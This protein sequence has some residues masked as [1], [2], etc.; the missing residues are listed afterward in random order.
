MFGARPIRGALRDVVTSAVGSRHQPKSQFDLTSLRIFKPTIGLP[1]WLRR[2]RA[3]GLAPIYNYFNRVPQPADEGYS[4]R[5][6]YCRDYRGGQWTYDGN[7][8][9]DFAL[10]VGTPVTASAPGEVLRVANDMKRGGLKVCIDHGRGLFT[11]SNH[12]AR[13]RVQPGD[14]VARGDII[15]RSGA[16]GIEFMLFFPW[17][18]PHL[19][20]NVWL[21]GQPVD[22]FASAAEVPL[23][24][25][26]DAPVP[27]DDAQPP[28]FDDA[29][30]PS[31][32]DMDAVATTIAG[33]ADP[34]LRARIE[35]ISDPRRRAAETL[36]MRNYMQAV[37]TERPKLYVDENDRRP[38]LDLPLHRKDYKGVW[39]PPS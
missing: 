12:L 20:F 17:V 21:D 22:P 28:D 34:Q 7:L 2:R 36:V 26:G 5:V 29:F 3:D 19:H 32:F 30:E 8:G 31:R 14:R 16:S 37:F 9:T 27:Y 25:G 39:H 10:P 13:A 1:A 11:T 6:T 33:C 24:R 23:W 4:V 15:A 35:A 38:C 18:A